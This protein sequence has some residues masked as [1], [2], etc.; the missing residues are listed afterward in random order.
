MP[1]MSA[2]RSGWR[3][4]LYANPFKGKEKRRPSIILLCPR[5][6]RLFWG[7]AGN[8]F[9][10]DSPPSPTFLLGHNLPRIMQ[11]LD[12]PAFCQPCQKPTQHQIRYRS[13]PDFVAQSVDVRELRT[14]KTPTTGT[15]NVLPRLLT[16]IQ[17]M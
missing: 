11:N 8:S 9:C 15:R 17:D 2:Q 16:R 4:R 3:E 14:E 6:E 13:D 10:D 7:P 1:N 5:K 12:R